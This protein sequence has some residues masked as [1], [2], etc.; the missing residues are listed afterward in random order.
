MRGPTCSNQA[1]YTLVELAVSVTVAGVITTGVVA[2]GAYVWAGQRI[3]DFGQ[4]MSML[5][6]ETDRLFAASNDYRQLNLETAVKLGLLKYE[7][8]EAAGSRGAGL[9]AVS[10]AFHIYSQPITLGVMDGP[11]FNKLAYGLHYARVPGDACMSLIHY[12]INLAD[13][14]AISPDP[15]TSITPTSFA[16]W[17]QGTRPVKVTNGKVEGF[18]AGYQ[19]LKNE[20]SVVPSMQ[21]RANACIAVSGNGGTFGLSLIRNKL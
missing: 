12:A 2:L 21:A 11:G 17:G 5:I 10:S 6:E 1:G 13:A 8:V 7:R 14:V 18:P 20:K 9:P 19:V 15:S 16:E 3:E 4:R